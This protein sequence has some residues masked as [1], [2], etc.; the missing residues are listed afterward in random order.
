MVEKESAHT[1]KKMYTGAYTDPSLE[2]LSFTRSFLRNEKWFQLKMQ[3]L[4]ARD[5]V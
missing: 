4:I 2:T 1:E 5:D 3:R